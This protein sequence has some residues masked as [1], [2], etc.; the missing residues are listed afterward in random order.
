VSET[1]ERFVVDVPDAVLADLR[2]RL[3]RARLPEPLADVG[4]EGGVDLDWLREI[5][6]Y[7]RSHYD[8]RAWER[9][10]NTFPHF[11]SRFEGER[12]HFVHRRSP[13]PDALPLLLAHGW[14]GSFFEFH[15]VIGPLADPRAHG[16]R[17]EDAFHVVCPSMPGFTFSDAPR[18]PGVDAQ[19]VAARFAALMQRLGYGRYGAQGGDWGATVASWIARLEPERCCGIHLN[20]LVVPRPRD[21]DPQGLAPAE[22]E[23]YE[24]TQRFL[25][26]G[27]VHVVVQG[28]E[29]DALGAALEDSP[30]G[31]AAWIAPRLRAWSD[32]NGDLERVFP[33]DE[34][35]THLTLYWVTRS[36]TSSLRLYA[37]SRRNGRLGR[38]DGR[39]DVPT[40]C[41]LFPRELFRPPRRWVERVHRVARWTEMPRGGH[42]AALEEP[43]LLV[44][45]IR[46]FF[47]P[48]RTE[49]R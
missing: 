45:D 3:V 40:G 19:R 11:R 20:L 17:T 44:E 23:A 25:A 27:P 12:L 35:L 2:E 49:K 36:I 1:V 42:F 31:L 15:K 16:G 26:T 46:A 18:A 33:R 47:R 21:E 9:R 34:L 10:L 13:E 37:E 38:P 7:W 39:S 48:L 14:P 30:A 5:V 4:W 29:P 22:R 41:A 32:C 8:W 43:E 28:Q 6:A 24:A